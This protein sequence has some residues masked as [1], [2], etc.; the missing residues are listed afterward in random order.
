MRTLKPKSPQIRPAPIYIEEEYS[1]EV[2]VE[3]VVVVYVTDSSE[4]IITAETE[5]ED[6]TYNVVAVSESD[7]DAHS[8]E[9]HD[10]MYAN[11][12]NYNVICKSASTEKSDDETLDQHPVNISFSD[13]A[14][15]MRRSGR[16]RKP[17][18]WMSSGTDELSKSVVNNPISS[19]NWFQKVNC[20]TSLA[21]TNL[22]QNDYY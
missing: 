2:P 10:E 22:F 4:K 11:E 16:H 1:D 9:A 12:T 18:V 19:R 13:S 21:N 17:P 7:G 20:I 14:E 15:P 6:T 8:Q 5:L 3:L